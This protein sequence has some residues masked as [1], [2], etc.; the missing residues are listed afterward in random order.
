M[1]GSLDNFFNKY[2]GMR[3]LS[4][5]VLLILIIF[6]SWRVFMYMPDVNFAVALCYGILVSACGAA[7]WKYMDVRKSE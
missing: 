3:R 7:I 1:T 2:K 5:S 6:A 4:K